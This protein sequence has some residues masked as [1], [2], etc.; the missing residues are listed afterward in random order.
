MYIIITC[1]INIALRSDPQVGDLNVRTGC[2]RQLALHL[3]LTPDKS[4]KASILRQ[5]FFR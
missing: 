3:Y 5:L 4:V 2:L 1:N